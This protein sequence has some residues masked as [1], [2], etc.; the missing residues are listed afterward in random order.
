MRKYWVILL[1]FF[2]SCTKNQVTEFRGWA[3][4]MPYHIII[5]K[6]LS[7]NQQKKV[8]EIIQNT[9]DETDLH[10]NIFNPKSEIS[11]I[12]EE[13]TKFFISKKFYKLLKICEKY[14]YLTDKFFDPSIGSIF[15]IWQNTLE[16]NKTI[17]ESLLKY[18]NTFVGWFHFK[19]EKNQLI[20]GSPFCKIDLNGIAK[21]YT[22]DLLV[23]RLCK[24]GYKNVFVE[25]GGDVMGLGKP[26][27]RFWQV[28]VLF[29]QT[30]K[31]ASLHNQACATSGSY[32]MFFWK[33]KKTKSY[34]PIFNPFT[35]RPKEVTKNSFNYVS[36]FAPNCTQADAF[37]TAAL[38]HSTKDQALN[39][40][41]KI[42]EKNS[43][44]SF[45]FFEEKEKIIKIP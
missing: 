24:L 16:K 11:K 23:D 27:K 25:W 35:K 36:V 2:V 45:W 38:S 3:M 12:N 31:I 8:L 20:K 19:I 4:T 32:K 29:P 44:I 10:F 22:I 6:N 40:A 18:Y 30:V 34:L 5:S 7:E 13:K 33:E 41:K 37:A 43:N 42:T 14:Y 26:S 9:F 15:S 28:Q 21:G 1:F 17:E 39:W